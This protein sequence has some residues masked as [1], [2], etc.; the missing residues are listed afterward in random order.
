MRWY[1]NIGFAITTNKD[2]I[3]TEEI[4]E[5]PYKGDLLKRSPRWQATDKVNDDLNITDQISVVADDFAYQNVGIMKYAE[6]SGSKWKIV[7][8][9]LQYPRIILTIGGVWNGN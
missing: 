9:D 6:L 7:S 2:D 8:A 3:Y 4:Q 1:G 5:K